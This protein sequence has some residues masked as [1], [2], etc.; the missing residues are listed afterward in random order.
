LG[1]LAGLQGQFLES[2]RR[3]IR[4]IQAYA[5]TRDPDGVQRNAGNF[6]ICHRRASPAEQAQ[7]RAMWEQAGLGK[8]PGDEGPADR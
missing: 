1:I 3:L 7:L 8:F 2:G 6:I 5:A 4:C